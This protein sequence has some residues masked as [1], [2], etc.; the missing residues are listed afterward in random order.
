MK[1]G[2]LPTVAVDDLKKVYALQN[3]VQ[4]NHPGQCGSI[5]ISV[6]KQVCTSG[7]DA[8]TVWF[9][10]SWLFILQHL[11]EAGHI[12]FPWIHDGKP[13]EAVFKALA[14]V[15]M[16]GMS[17]RVMGKGLPFDVEGLCRMVQKESES[18]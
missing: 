12:K 8:G 11:N 2:L 5:S 4:S 18:S 17:P 7:S 13:D 1:E 15:P 10:L 6:Y 9:R 16:N 3:E 14:V